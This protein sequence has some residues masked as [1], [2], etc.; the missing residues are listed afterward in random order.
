MQGYFIENEMLRRL[1][2]YEQDMIPSALTPSGLV[3]EEMVASLLVNIIG[4]QLMV[5]F[6]AGEPMEGT[7]HHRVGHRDDGPFSPAPGR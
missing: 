4:P 3:V 7:G 1:H 5:W 2:G 6:M